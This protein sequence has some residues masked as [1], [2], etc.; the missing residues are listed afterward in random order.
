MWL[1]SSQW[2]HFKSLHFTTN[3]QTWYMVFCALVWAFKVYF[4]NLA[5]S[6]VLQHPDIGDDQKVKKNCPVT[7]FIETCVNFFFLLFVVLRKN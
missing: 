7:C 4:S 1:M 3:N 5:N 2:K 6:S